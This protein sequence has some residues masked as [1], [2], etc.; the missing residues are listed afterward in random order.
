MEDDTRPRSAREDR[1]YLSAAIGHQNR[2][3]LGIVRTPDTPDDETLRGR[4]PFY[5]LAGVLIILSVVLGQPLLFL[6]GLFVAVL[7]ALPEIWYRWGYS[8]LVVRHQLSTARTAFGDTVTVTLEMENRKALPLQGL[9]LDDEFPDA[10]PV[11][12]MRL[13]TSPRTERA[14]NAML[15]PLWAYQRVRRHYRVVAVRRGV[16]TFGPVNL[17]L[18]DPFALLTREV[19]HEN[20]ASLLVYP[21]LA[22]LE[23]FGLPAHAPL[24]E[25]AIKRQLIEDPL[26]VAGVRPYVPGDEPRRIHWKATA[27][28]GSPQSKV[29]EPSARHTIML[30]LDLRTFLSPGL[31]YAPDAVELAI[32]VAASVARYGI[33][34]GYAVGIAAN[35]RLA[36]PELGDAPALASP[37]AMPAQAKSDWIARALADAAV[38]HQLRL[39]PASRPEQLNLLLDGLAR[40]LPYGGTPM[41]ELLQAETHRLPWGSTVVYIGPETLVDVPALVALRK[42]RSQGHA[43]TLLVTSLKPGTL[44]E[45]DHDLHVAD[46]PVHRVGG[47]STWQALVAETLGPGMLRRASSSPH[48]DMTPAQRHAMYAGIHLGSGAQPPARE[49]AADATPTKLVV[50]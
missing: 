5:L 7:I 15:V 22:P 48:A 6:G 42:M 4:G 29:L 35:G 28:V 3:A 16:H 11:L 37:S 47:P 21:L 19:R 31:G 36:A 49:E 2:L 45:A 10:L 24:G 26:R 41:S 30:M 12:G 46:F 50:G 18:S 32:C 38:P 34:A 9:R 23:R 8:R 13:V 39:P 33:A 44:T 14:R 40:M 1:F 43:V 20:T 17:R 25:H 27:R